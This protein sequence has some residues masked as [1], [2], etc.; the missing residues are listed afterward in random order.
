MS[1]EQRARAEGHARITQVTVAGD[2]V[3]HTPSVGPPTPAAPGLPAPPAAL[4]GRE[5]SVRVLTDLLDEGG[6]PVTVVAGLP[7]VGK[8][9]LAVATAHRALEY[10]WFDERVF[11][12]QLHGYAPNGAVSGSQAVREMLRGLGVGDAD[13]PPSPEGQVALYRARLASLARAGQRVLIVADDA[14]AVSQ[15]QDLVPPDGTHRLLVT[16]RH[17]LVAPGFAARVVGLDELGVEPAAELIAGALLRTWPE[18]PRPA[19]ERQAL[20]RIAEHCGRLPLALTVAGAL[21][22]G[23]PGLPAAE[24]ARQLARARNRLETLHVDGDVPV[25]VRAAFDLSYA[26][27]PADQARLFRLLTVVPGPDCSTLHAA[28]VTGSGVAFE[29]IT[30]AA[31]AELRPAL[32]ALVRASLLAEQPVGSG[33]W[34]MHNL[35]RLYALERGE[36]RAQQDGRERAVERFLAWLIAELG[37]A[38]AALGLDGSPQTGRGFSS[39]AALHWFETERLVASATVAFAAEAGRCKDALLMSVDLGEYLKVYGHIRDLLVMTRQVVEAARR[40]GDRFILGVALSNYG[41]ALVDGG[42]SEEGV[43][44]LEEALS[45]LRGTLREGEGK[46]L[47]D[48]GQAYSEMNRLEE[49]RE[50]SE[51]AL[52]IFRELGNL[53]DQGPPLARLSYIYSRM[54]RT[55]ESVDFLRQAIGLM[56]ETG[57]RHREA[58]WSTS[59]AVVLWRSGHR[60]ESL[61]VAQRALAVRRELGHRAGVAWSLTCLAESLVEAGRPQEAVVGLEEAVA[62]FGEVGD[63]A[64]QA[65]ALSDLGMLYLKAGRLEEG[66]AAAERAHDLLAGTGRPADEARAAQR[67][68]VGLALLYRMG[69]AVPVFER[70]ADCFGAAGLTRQEADCREVAEAVRQEAS[71]MAANTEGA[72]PPLGPLPQEQADPAAAPVRPPVAEGSRWRDRLMPRLRR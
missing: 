64:R 6:A 1:A 2:Y 12:L 15:V 8:S 11:F 49:A 28:L 24:L 39:A 33:R 34:R 27:L 13:V 25:G 68:A 46:V 60:Q 21:L 69:E 54:G 56:R 36:E 41:S 42:R 26:R 16:S 48:L 9:A 61:A 3:T 52:R 44:Q 47:A 55:D 66:L 51:D 62:L 30:A 70:A 53:H 29:D 32:A 17:R 4:V 59:L 22:A 23:D 5:N 35:V 45:L 19:R 67:R 57:D 14:G 65:P 40:R 58:S 20:G 31:G 10:G 50:A 72:R 38:R 43:E 7:G 63:H 37:A 18:D 71:A